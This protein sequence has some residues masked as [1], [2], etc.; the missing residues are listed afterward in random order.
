MLCK[1]S[2]LLNR[3]GRKPK[4]SVILLDWGVRESYHSLDYLNRQTIPRDEYELIW[5]EFYDRKPPELARLVESSRVLDK[6]IV[7]GYPDDHIFHKHRLYNVGILASTGD[8]CVICDSDAIFTPKF[9]ETIIR[10]FE[11]TPDAVIHLDEIRNNDRRFYPF[12]YPSIEAVLGPGCMNWTGTMSFGLYLEHDRTHMANYGACMAARKRDILAVGGADEHLDYLGYICGPYD[13]TFRIVNHHGQAE[14]WL[15]NEYLYHVWHPNT[16]GI[17]SDYQGP[18]DGR[19]MSLR[20]LDARSS[21]RVE[22]YLRSPLMD[23]AGRGLEEALAF[24]AQRPEPGWVAG[25]QPAGPSEEVFWAAREH[26]GFNVFCHRGDWLALPVGEGRYDPARSYRVILTAPTQDL[27]NRRIASYL[28][29]CG[30][31]TPGPLSR[32]MQKFQSQPLHRLPFR[33]WRKMRRLASKLAPPA[34]PWSR[35]VEETTT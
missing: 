19:M 28:R 1:P 20:A 15:D 8:V 7:L 30:P 4:V 13:L 24:L 10:A 6:W 18:E 2:L 34:S 27:L 3:A 17:N 14:R 22:P 29:V 33:V 11:E 16:S 35:T 21:Y 25:H 9:I 32:L 12:A 26:G 23:F 5:L 31:V